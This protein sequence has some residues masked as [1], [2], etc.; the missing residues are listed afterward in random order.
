VLLRAPGPVRGREG[1]LRSFAPIVLL[2]VERQRRR[3][4]RV[5]SAQ[6][7]IAARRL[8]AP[9]L[10]L[11]AL[12][13][14]ELR[15]PWAAARICVL[16]DHNPAGARLWG[17]DPRAIE[18][19]VLAALSVADRS[20]AVTEALASW[21]AANGH[22]D[23]GVIPHGWEPAENG[24]TAPAAAMASL[25]RPILL[26]A[27]RVDGR[28][29][30]GELRRLAESRVG[31]VVTVG[32]WLT[33]AD[34]Q[35]AE[36]PRVAALEPVA[37]GVLPAYLRAADC[38]L[39]PYVADEW[40]RYGLPAKLNE[41][42]AAGPPIAASGYASLR[43][44][45]GQLLQFAAEGDLVAAVQR[46]IDTDSDRARAARHAHAATRPWSEQARRLLALVE[47]L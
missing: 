2:P 35:L 37:P 26:Y 33:S 43:D 15:T 22:P 1:N 4:A 14:P 44:L 45:D 20:Y 36:H 38:L 12:L 5:V 31:T 17:R 30:F 32:P 25:E 23:C 7:G 13:S 42:L 9:R 46:A 41:Y 19:N 28:L 6:I 29:D 34:R 47:D 10:V 39:L 27:G 11:D 18:R 21:A 24:A 8:P 16:K 3:N 40:A